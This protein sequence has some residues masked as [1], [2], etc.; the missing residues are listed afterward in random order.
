MSEILGKLRR[1]MWEG[2]SLLT[3]Y[4]NGWQLLLFRLGLLNYVKTTYEGKTCVIKNR[5]DYKD[6][7]V[8]ADKYPIK[9]GT[10]T[11]DIVMKSMAYEYPLN[12]NGKSVV[13][14][15][16]G[17]GDSALS[18]VER[19][20]K[21]VLSYEIDPETYKL[22]RSNLNINNAECVELY[23]LGV[24][25]TSGNN[26]IIL[27]EIIQKIQQPA[28]LKLDCEGAE[29]D[30][31]RKASHSAI[32]FFDEIEMEY[33]NGYVSLVKLFDD[34]GYQTKVSGEKKQGL[35]TAIKKRKKISSSASG[36]RSRGRR[37]GSG[38][39]TGRSA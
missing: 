23:N 33:H 37:S 28:I 14:V 12:P 38:R 36:F 4:D 13:D 2:Y 18:F 22:A 34:L 10:Q 3:N 32:T 15:G 1:R 8:N 6:F 35:L 19:G 21:K 11:Y 39:C 26:T 9:K 5:T 31:L 27:D 25:G 30:I 16:A 24:S 20:A 29:Y 7:F 17:K